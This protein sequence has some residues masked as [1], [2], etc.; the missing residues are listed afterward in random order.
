[1]D[2]P[3]GGYSPSGGFGLLDPA[4]A[5]AEASRLAALRTAAS[6]GP[7][8]VPMSASFASGAAPGTIQAVHHSAWKLTGCA[9]LML[10]G[11]VV[12]LRARRLGRR[13]RRRARLPTAQSHRMAHD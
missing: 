8:S 13:W 11:L 3:T 4:G 5:L 2:R 12:L 1:M 7:G 6:P 9:L 10:A